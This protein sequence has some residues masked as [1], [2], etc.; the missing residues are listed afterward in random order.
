[1]LAM[2]AKAGP[3][4][5]LQGRKTRVEAGPAI[6]T[7]VLTQDASLSGHLPVADQAQATRHLAHDL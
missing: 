4:G 5:E 3:A 1:M 6:A 7:A 2:E